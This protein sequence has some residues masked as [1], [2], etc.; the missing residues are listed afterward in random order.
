MK[1]L[2]F[3]LL[4]IFLVCRIAA[5]TH[6]QVLFAGGE[7]VDFTCVG[8]SACGVTTGS[9]T[10]R[11]S[12][13]RAAYYASSGGAPGSIFA[14]PVFTASSSIWVHGQFCETWI[15]GGCA[16]DPGGGTAT[17][18]NDEMIRVIDSAG[19]PTLV[20]RGTGA[21]GQLEIA[22]RSAG[23]AYTHL[24]TCSSAFA[25][26]LTQLDFYINYTTT[27]EVTLYS[28]SAPVC[29]YTGNVTNGDGAT[30]LDQ[31][32]FSVPLSS[33]GGYTNSGLWS[34]IIVATSRTT[35]MNL[36]TLAPSG[37]GNAIQ[38]NNSSGSTPCTSIL[39]A[40]TINT[41]NFVYTNSNN[42]IEECTVTNSIPTGLYSPLALVMS[43]NALVGGSG[44]QHFAFA[45]RISGSGDYFSS[46][47]APTNSFSNISN[48]IQSTNP[49]TGS[50]WAITD[51][52][53]SG[54]NIGLRS[55]P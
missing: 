16:G 26:S 32:Q 38:W 9:G 13:A 30:T 8:S 12:W 18:A 29:D 52:T 2:A 31:V 25:V 22:S 28:N 20:V 24:V 23:G 36:Y 43:T 15:T 7:D 11:S 54:F 4:G 10:F 3:A 5:P 17:T 40:T 37:N 19:N 33:G 50:P 41:A 45:T 49:A 6:A 39:N 48:Y 44:P 42:Q 53:A 35:T 14:T 51:L 34:E 46:N 55:E 21:S 27:G 47:F 1:R